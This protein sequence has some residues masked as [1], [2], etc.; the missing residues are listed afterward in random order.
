[1][2]GSQ[3]DIVVTAAV[4]ALA[5][6][7]AAASPPVA[8][9]TVLG[10]ALLPMPGYLLAQLL[11]GPGTAALER[12]LVAVG[13]AFIVPIVG[14]LAL[15]NAGVPLRRA[16]WLAVLGGVTLA[17]DVALLVR[18]R[19]GRAAPFRWQL[20]WRLP[21]WHVAAFGA[22]VVIAA[23]AVGLARVGAAVQP[24]P[25][26]TQ[27]WLSA[28]GASAGTIKIGVTNDEGSTVDY[29]LV[30]LRKGHANT[31]WNVTLPN[32]DTWQLTV[33]F[34]DKSSLTANLYRLPDVTTPYRHV[35]TN[36]DKGLGL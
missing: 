22:A 27:L 13:L 35:D 29:R 21:R 36:G 11:L 31:T 19:A 8:V 7:A 16:S 23:C 15:Y 20:G 14:G 34:N 28:R 1:M 24:E 30:L 33:P 3:A 2:R 17:A 26:F 6:G 32:G 25:S 18:R 12:A 9:T 5:C 4:A 10:L